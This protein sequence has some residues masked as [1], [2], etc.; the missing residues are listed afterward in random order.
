M[1]DRV[2][3]VPVASA[4][5]VHNRYEPKG[6]ARRLFALHDT[7][8]ILYGGA[9]TGK[10]RAHLELLN[11]CCEL[12]PRMRGLVLRLTRS[13]LT[14]TALVTLQE[15]VIAP[16]Q[17]VTFHHGQQEFRYPNGSVIVIGGLDDAESASKIMSGQYDRIHVVECTE[18][19]ERAWSSLTTRLRN[20]R[21]PYQQIVGCCNPAPGSWVFKRGERGDCVLLKSLHTDNPSVTPEYEA[22]L[23]KLRGTLGRSLRDGEWGHAGGS[24]QALIGLL[25]LPPEEEHFVY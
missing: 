4:P 5:L 25:A 19:G 6:A 13:S 20:H 9:G 15:E 24:V 7:E 3:F 2:A 11:L 14:Q 17:R 12:Y 8:V 18:V 22:I 23:K 1:S 21:M 16:G 10:T